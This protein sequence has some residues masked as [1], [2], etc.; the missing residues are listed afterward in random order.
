MDVPGIPRRAIA[1]HAFAPNASHAGLRVRP[2]FGAAHSRRV[3]TAFLSSL[4]GLV[5]CLEHLPSDESLGYSLSSCG[6][7]LT[8]SGPI[9]PAGASDNSPPFQRWVPRAHPTPEPRRG[10]RIRVTRRVLLPGA[11]AIRHRLAVPRPAQVATK[12]LAATL[13]FRYTG[14]YDERGP[15]ECG[16]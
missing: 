7:G 14:P 6:L 8:S 10:D 11:V 13:L 16:V 4:A 15:G 9:R 1:A 3:P 2:E 5:L 12:R